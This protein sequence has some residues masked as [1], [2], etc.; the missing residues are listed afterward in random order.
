MNPILK[1]ILAAN[2][3]VLTVL[4]FI[5]PH[6]MLAPGK[7][8]PAHRALTN[9][10]FACHTPFKGVNSERCV[11][12]H[13][14]A[15]IGFRLTTGQPI[16]KPTA[17]TLFHQQLIS[18]DCVACHSD[19][20][21]VK[22]FQDTS[23]FNHALLKTDIREQCQNCHKSPQ[24]SLHNQIS[25][26]CGQC[27][28]QQQ[29]VPAKFDHND[30]FV[31]D[32][33]HNTRCVTCHPRNDYSQYTCYGCHEHS[34]ASIRRKHIEEGIRNFDNCVRCHR[35][36]DDHDVREKGGKRKEDDDD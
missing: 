5:Y 18:Q 4:V 33:D 22:R 8:I 12:C 21:G 15:D 31:L 35:S 26:D 36:A 10:C 11:D 2:L 14:P 25:A 24:D 28:T 6:L 30:F 1:I 16:P 34:P 9:D 32:N 23:H 13:K 17:S 27:H 20:A 3:I 29:W 19:H 7:L